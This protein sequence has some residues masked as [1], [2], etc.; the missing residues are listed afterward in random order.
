[1]FFV[2]RAG[3]R[4]E[5]TLGELTAFSGQLHFSSLAA[6]HEALSVRFQ[7]CRFHLQASWY[8]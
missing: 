4:S 1:M 6:L 2:E 5:E 3:K 7:G 8:I